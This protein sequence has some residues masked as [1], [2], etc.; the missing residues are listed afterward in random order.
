MFNI[1]GKV[2]IGV[3]IAVAS[4][5]GY[6]EHIQPVEPL[7]AFLPTAGGTYRLQSSIGLTDSSVSL[8]SF[9]EPISNILYTMSYLGST[10]EYGTLEPGNSTKKEFIS[11]TGITQNS[12]GSATLTGVTRGLAFST[13]FTASTT[14]QQTHSGQSIFILSNTPQFY[15]QFIQK[16]AAGTSTAIL[17][18]SSTTPWGY[19]SGMNVGSAYA[20][21]SNFASKGYVDGV[22]IAGAADASQAVKGIV[23]EATAAEASS[24]AADGSGNTSAPL[25]LTASNATSTCQSAA[26]RVTVTALSTGKLAA[27]CI[28]Q[29]ISYGWTA[30]TTFNNATTTFLATTSILATPGASLRLNGQNY[31]IDSATGADQS[32]L[33]TNGSNALSWV[34]KAT[35]S[36]AFFPQTANMATSTGAPSLTNTRFDASAYIIPFTITVN[37]VSF[38]IDGTVSTPGT[39]LFGIYREDGTAF[40]ST[41]TI[42]FGGAGQATS[43]TLQSAVTLFPGI[44]YMGL[45]ANGTTNLAVYE[46]GCRGLG[47]DIIT[48]EPGLCG[49][50]TAA[51]ST[52][53]ASINTVTGFSVGN[54]GPVIRLDN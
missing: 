40:L 41:T 30:S 37:K 35:T 23:E 27:G 21:S 38:T 6:K 22:S 17:A 26:N 28:D 42:K 46:W 51:A 5:F 12:D 32:V 54:A 4:F 47:N 1:L 7:G 33:T 43:T 25:V 31:T 3:F 11:F 36:L 20:S 2:V 44:Y 9:K 52:L 34:A 8:S 16:N 48:N 39:L 53:P 29:T 19:D 10:I 14:L 49:A 45:M 15:G 24:G 13:P 50:V 18:V